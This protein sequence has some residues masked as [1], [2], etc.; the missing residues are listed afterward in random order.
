MTKS[1]EDQ[2]AEVEHGVRLFKR[3]VLTVVA[4]LVVALIA[5]V[6]FATTGDTAR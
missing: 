3:V 1:F 6:Y 2:M 4:F 5:F